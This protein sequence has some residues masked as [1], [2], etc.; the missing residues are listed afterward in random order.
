MRHPV[1]QS[2][3]PLNI[4]IFQ[5]EPHEG[6]GSI[7]N[8]AAS[9]G[10]RIS[11]THFHQGDRLPNLSDLDGLI[12]MGG[13]MNVYETAAYP[14]LLDE[15][16]FIASA[17]AAGKPVLGICLGAQLLAVVLGAVVE[18]NRHKEIGW[19]PIY[20]T[21]AADALGLFD[22]FPSEMDAF[23]W[24]G[25]MFHLPSGATHLARSTACENQAFLYGDRVVGFQFH[26][27]MTPTG[28][29]Q[30]IQSGLSD[31]G[32]FIQSAEAILAEP[33][34]FNRMNDLLHRWLSV[35]FTGT[36]PGL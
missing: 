8:W 18:P 17:I 30:M 21:G 36:S 19:F 7:L 34:R 12:V 24:H 5:H 32:P 31:P 33:A 6:P 25:D 20:K 1:E 10:H 14:W 13:S 2:E 29:E 15:K 4:H 23:H 16:S 3:C 22:I 9:Q 28:A 11:T 26:L 35:F 27:E